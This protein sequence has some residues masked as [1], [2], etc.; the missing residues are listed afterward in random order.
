[1]LFEFKLPDV[2]EGIHE[3]EIL[4]WLVAE[5]EAV[6]EDQPIV[7]V[8]TD[9]AVV[10]LPAPATGTIKQRRV[11][12][13]EVVRVGTVIVVIET[14]AA[15]GAGRAAAAAPT[16]AAAT[17][18]A[19]TAPAAA[20]PARGKG[21][22][23]LAT[24]ATRRLA[25]EL[26][27]DLQQVPGSGEGG[28]VTDDD[29]RRF[30]AGATPPPA[31]APPAAALAAGAPAPAAP[32]QFVT[33]GA[34]R[35]PL[36]GIRKVI[37]ANMV[38]AKSTAPHVA[39]VDEADMSALIALRDELRAQFSEVKITYLPLIIK[40]VVAALKQFP[41]INASL[42]DAAQ[43]III[44]KDYHIGMAAATEAGLMVPVVRHADQKSVLAI[45]QETQDLAQRARN[46]RLAPQELSG[47]TFTI[48]NVGSIGSL[49]TTPVINHPE[50]AILGV[51]GIQERPVVRDGQIVIRPMVYLTLS[52]D[53]RV[54]DGDVAAR[55]TR[56]V[57]RYLE[58]PNLLLAEMI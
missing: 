21:R 37:A 24:P 25:R 28:R 50:V 46:R 16:P 22:R 7:E 34:E 36:R 55:F 9:K 11:A 38:R 12:E 35:I 4:R 26:G 27:V 13:G 18:P 1:M 48:T 14:D 15:P 23:A 43:E 30:A 3:A 52:F 53:H 41:T 54:N 45:A 31:A 57:I 2:G 6:S 49:F 19:A 32:G 42:D 44:H 40:A 58:N 17:A 33:R 8:Q 56:T 47:S 10:E 29:V 5:G 39:N 51:H 20:A